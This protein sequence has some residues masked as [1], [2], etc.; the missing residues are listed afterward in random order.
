MNINAQRQERFLAQSRPPLPI[1]AFSGP[2]D[3]TEIDDWIEEFQRLTSFGWN[4]EDRKSEV[5]RYLRGAAAIGVRSFLL[6]NPESTWDELRAYFTTFRHRSYFKDWLKRFKKRKQHKKEGPRAYGDVLGLM[7]RR[8]NSVVPEKISGQDLLKRFVKGL[9]DR[10]M[11]LA[12]RRGNPR[13]I[14]EAIKRALEEDQM[15]IELFSSKK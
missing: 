6:E 8:I 5:G 4:D 10:D 2:E 14:E 9:R 1:S 7:A 3:Q 12:I 13:N 15:A 11:R